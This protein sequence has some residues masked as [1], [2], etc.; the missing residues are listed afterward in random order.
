MSSVNQSKIENLTTNVGIKLYEAWVVNDN[1]TIN[2]ISIVNPTGDTSKNYSRNWGGFRRLMTIG[3]MLYND[4]TDKSI[5]SA[6]KV[7]L[8]DQRNYT[9][10]PG[11]VIQAKGTGDNVSAITY[12]ITVYEDG[13]ANTYYG[14]IEDISIAATSDE[15]N[16]LRGTLNLFESNPN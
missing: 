9:N 5:T 13:S 14:S 3:F 10:G 8:S 11:G 6:N 2:N 1:V 16:R 12:R 7:T 4:G 15:C